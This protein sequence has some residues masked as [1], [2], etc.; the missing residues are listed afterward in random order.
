ME[1]GE[2]YDQ[3]TYN[4]A[5][6]VVSEYATVGVALDV[7]TGNAF[8][9][10]FMRAIRRLFHQVDAPRDW[11]LVFMTRLGRRHIGVMRYGRVKHNNG[12]G[13][14][15]SVV[16]DDLVYIRQRYKTTFWRLNDHSNLPQD[17]RGR[18]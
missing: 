7:D 5:H 17:R 13:A 1:I 15:G 6:A 12:C 2:N 16:S 11:D 10:S 4:C 18:G 3:L 14:S 9:V 8:S